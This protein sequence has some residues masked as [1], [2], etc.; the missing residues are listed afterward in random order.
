MPWSATTLQP[1]K[2][3]TVNNGTSQPSGNVVVNPDS[4]WDENG[5]RKPDSEHTLANPNN[6]ADDLYQGGRLKGRNKFGSIFEEEAKEQVAKDEQVAADLVRATSGDE[7]DEE[8]AH[9]L[10]GE[11]EDEKLGEEL[12]LDDVG[13]VLNEIKILDAARKG[14]DEAADDMMLNILQQEYNRPDGGRQ[15]VK[16]ALSALG[17]KKPGNK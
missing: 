3:A 8:V 10:E 13:A 11:D 4:A 16:G 5:K 12:N 15:R 14:G 6:I 7:D 2:G 1:D 17:Y 9:L